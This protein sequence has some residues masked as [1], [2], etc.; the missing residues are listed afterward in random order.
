MP[1]V[2]FDAGNGAVV[3]PTCCSCVPCCCR[4]TAA[5]GPSGR[6]HPAPHA[7]HA[8]SSLSGHEKGRSPSE[9]RPPRAIRL[10]EEVP[11]RL[12]GLCGAAART[13]GALAAAGRLALRGLLDGPFDLLAYTG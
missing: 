8:S 5:Q 6:S 7:E 13:S 1:S 2:P 12:F 4:E 9:P 3:F 11:G 10:L